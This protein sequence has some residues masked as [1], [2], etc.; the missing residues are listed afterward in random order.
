[1]TG[2]LLAERHPGLRTLFLC[3][4]AQKAGTS[5]LA[6]VLARHPLCH[7]PRDKELHYWTMV[8]RPIT[9]PDFEARRDY[10]RWAQRRLALSLLR[11]SPGRVRGAL[12][13]VRRARRELATLRDPSAERYV[14][15]LM[16][17]HRGQPVAGEATPEYATLGAEAFRQMAALH[18]D[19]RF[20]L[21]M[22]DPVDRLWSSI[23][24]RFRT[25]IRSTEALAP[26]IREAFAE[27]LDPARRTFRL[28]D[29]AAT[30]EALE[31]AVGPERVHC[32]FFETM[33]SR[34]EMDRLGAFLG[35]GPIPFEAERRVNGGTR[36]ALRPDPATLARARE[37][38]DPVYRYVGERFAPAVPDAWR[39]H[40][41]T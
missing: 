39:L 36:D 12:W 29:Y 2:A 28:G 27:A 31:A 14:R 32:M 11:P 33:R 35:I 6:G 3:V 25:D 16:R 26:L 8:Q 21:V 15:L 34:A 37:A 40:G 1:M 17:G 9:P 7:M 30:I 38:L 13:V 19:T 20:I 23:R 41:A 5:W 10:L 4:G 22:R 24:H 18:P